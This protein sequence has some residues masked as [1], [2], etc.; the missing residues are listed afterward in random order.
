MNSNII[1]RSHFD[2]IHTITDT[3]IF[4][5]IKFLDI[6][7]KQL[8]ATKGTHKPYYYPF[9]P[10]IK[11]NPGKRRESIFRF[12][13]ESI[14]KDGKKIP[15]L[16]KKQINAISK[17]NKKN[18]QIV[19]YVQYL[20]KKNEKIDLFL[21]LY[22]NGNIRVRSTLNKPISLE[23]LETVIYNITNPII[24]KINKILEKSVNNKSN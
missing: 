22:E 1:K 24:I 14:S 5:I 8:H 10:L 19:L 18:N 20:T 17:D 12:Y 3:S 23:L 2:I 6:I 21:D 16:S 9:V 11:Y 7:F 13:S 4:K 15:W